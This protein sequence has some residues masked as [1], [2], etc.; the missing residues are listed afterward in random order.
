MAYFVT[1]DSSTEPS[2]VDEDSVKLSTPDVSKDLLGVYMTFQ[3][4]HLIR[5]CSKVYGI[6]LFES[7]TK[8]QILHIICELEAAT[9]SE[10]I[11]WNTTSLQIEVER[12]DTFY[13][14]LIN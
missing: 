5:T 3:K 12:L 6:T 10:K 4:Y 7:I 11:D 9:S 14:Y 8:N 13:N 2:S 1:L